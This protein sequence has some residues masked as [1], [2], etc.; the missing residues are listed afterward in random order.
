[1]SAELH[2]ERQ[3]AQLR[4][5]GTLDRE[6]LTPLW[7][8]RQSITDG[9]QRI[10]LSGLA[11]VDTA[12]LALLVHLVA[13]TQ[14]GGRGVALEGMSENLATLAKLYNLPENLLPTSTD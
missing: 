7:E 10:D 4:L 2:W 11:R 3:E 13:L 8:Q 5:N 9:L 1:M 14:A 12:G 6:T